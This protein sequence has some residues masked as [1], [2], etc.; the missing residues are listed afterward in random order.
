MDH[1]AVSTT[2]S[3]KTPPLPPLATDLKWAEDSK[4]SDV[5]RGAFSKFEK[6]TIRAAVRAVAEKHNMNPEDHSWLFATSKFRTEKKADKGIWMEVAQALP[7]R[8]AKS[9]WRCGVRLLHPGNFQVST[10]DVNELEA[11]QQSLV[12]CCMQ[13]A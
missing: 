4:R 8:T 9:V 10:R 3:S 13:W 2:S 12:V 7:H 6:D 11:C 5:K 1:P